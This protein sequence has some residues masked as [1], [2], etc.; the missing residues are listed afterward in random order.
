[1]ATI[2]RYGVCVISDVNDN[3]YSSHR[4]LEML[5]HYIGNFS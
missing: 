1:M 3:K 4:S 2:D 5:D